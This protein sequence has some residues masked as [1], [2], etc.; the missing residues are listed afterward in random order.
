VLYFAADGL[1]SPSFG[2]FARSDYVA[3]HP[4]LIRKFVAASVKGWNAMLND[5][6]AVS[7]AIRDQIKARPQSDLK[8]APILASWRL[9]QRFVFTARTKG[10]PFGWESQADWRDALQMLHTHAGLKGSLDPA[11]Y[12]TNAYLP[13]R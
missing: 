10:H 2:L 5:P 3:A 6:K 8:A 11:D 12:F 1:I 13:Q 7:E 9:Y 4:D